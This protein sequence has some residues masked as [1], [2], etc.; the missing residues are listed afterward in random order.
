M[1]SSSPPNSKEDSND[2]EDMR[3][4]QD[5]MVFTDSSGSNSVS[6]SESEDAHGLKVLCVGLCRTDI[7]QVCKGFPKECSELECVDIRW[8]RGGNASNTCTVLAQFDTPVEFLGTLSNQQPGLKSLIQDMDEHK[9]RHDH[10]PFKP[11]TT[12][13][14]SSIVINSNNLTRTR[15]N[16][17]PDLPELTASEFKALRLEDYSWIHFEGRN[18]DNVLE[19]MQIVH[20]RNVL[21]RSK[22]F[23]TPYYPIVIS[24]ELNKNREGIFKLLP[25]VDVI[26]VGENFMTPDQSKNMTK[27]LEYV[28]QAHQKPG[29]IIVCSR[30]ERGAL[31]RAPNGE[32]TQCPAQQSTKIVDIYGTSDTFNAAMIYFLNQENI[33]SRNGWRPISM[34]PVDFDKESPLEFICPDILYQALVFACRASGAKMGFKGFAPLRNVYKGLTVHQEIKL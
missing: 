1:S 28:C 4:L 9:I 12:C 15:W 34:V 23:R 2:N 19:M 3:F 18:V 30:D 21:I 25:Y 33:S 27:T 17:N 31:G 5:I 13:P 32:F 22:G 11:N 16:Y 10:C 8:E 29:V 6:S 14:T 7:I 20:K 24:L 26:F